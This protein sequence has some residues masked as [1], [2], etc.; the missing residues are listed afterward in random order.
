MR[1]GGEKREFAALRQRHLLGIIHQLQAGPGH[2]IPHRSRYQH[3]LRRGKY[4]D[5]FRHFHRR[6]ALH[7][8]VQRVAFPGV[9]AH[10]P[11][12]SRPPGYPRQ[13]H[14]APHGARRPVKGNLRAAA[15]E[16]DHVTPV[17]LQ[18]PYDLL[19]QAFH[20]PLALHRQH[21]R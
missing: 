21:R 4:G 19:T 12:H 2:Q 14:R 1:V 5:P 16:S 9:Y 8:A 15:A 11:H 10:P 3:L 18:L 6:P 17:P 20:R 7:L 13:R